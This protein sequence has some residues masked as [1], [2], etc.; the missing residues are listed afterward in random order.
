MVTVT[1]NKVV[2]ASKVEQVSSLEDQ[3][4]LPE[5]IDTDA[6]DVEST[7]SAAADKSWTIMVY[8]DAENNLEEAAIDDLYEMESGGGTTADVNVIVLIDRIPG[9][10][11]T[12]PDW[13]E[14]RYYQVMENAGPG[15]DSLMLSNLGEI[16]M[17]SPTT[18]Q[19]FIEFCFDNF[20]ADYYCLDIWDHGGGVWGAAWDDTSG[21]DRLTLNEM[22]TAVNGACI[23][24]TERIDVFAMDCCV[25]NMIEMGYEMREYCDYFVASEENIPWD[26]FDYNDIISE[27]LDSPTM[28]PLSFCELLVDAYQREYSIVGTTC[29]SAI[30]LTKI[31]SAVTVFNNFSTILTNFIENENF[32]YTFYLAR[33][34]SRTFFDTHFV[35]IIDLA[36]KIEYLSNIELIDEVCL[37]LIAVIEELVIYNWQHSSYSGTAYGMSIFLPTTDSQLPTGAMYD[38]AD[39]VGVFSGM[40]WQT[41]TN[42]GEFVRDCYDQYHLT[43]PENPPSYHIGART[44]TINLGLNDHLQYF[45]YVQDTAI[46]DFSLSV[47]SGDIDF[48]IGTFTSSGFEILGVSNLV[49][50]SD[51]NQEHIRLSLQK[52]YHYIFIQGKSADCSFTL[53]SQRYYIPTIAMQTPYNYSSGSLE[54]DDSGHYQQTVYHYYLIELPV[55]SLSFIINNSATSNYE[56]SITFLTIDLLLHAEPVGAGNAIVIDFDCSAETTACIIIVNVDGYGSFQL[57]VDGTMNYIVGLNPI[58]LVSLFIFGLIV[59]RGTQFL[60]LKKKR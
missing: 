30:N 1:Q 18:L 25:M 60:K 14:A 35:D 45:V 27:L 9:H 5:I 11:T 19:N 50:P 36:Y 52:Q 31:D 39:Q 24:Y 56:V 4:F 47:T 46:Y 12:N 3:I 54:G 37:S 43:Q 7:I 51:G 8:L 44:E 55:D 10:Y 26:G 20:S 15:I 40:D 29:L 21:S 49:N 33:T 17:G 28:S 59:L 22:Q 42:W 2:N 58:Q 6:V 32:G 53:Y 13:T 16:N 23:A 57:Y 48:Q 41:D 38:Y 34:S